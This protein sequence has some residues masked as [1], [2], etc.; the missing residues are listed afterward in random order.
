L[1]KCKSFGLLTP[2]LM[3]ALILT[4]CGGSDSAQ[5]GESE[6]DGDTQGMDHGETSGM[7]HDS[8]DQGVGETTTANEEVVNAEA[9]GAS[10]ELASEPAASQPGQPVTLS[11]RITD[12]S[13]QTLTNLPLDHERPMHLI[14][15]SSDLTQFQHI[16]PEIGTGDAYSVTTEFP[17]AGTYTL[18]DEFVY[19]GHKVLDRREL[20]VGE[21]ADTAPS[22]TRDLAP[23]TE[24]TITVAISGPE[25]IRA[26]EESSFTFTLT[27]GERSVT[28]LEPYLGA[29]AHVAVVSEDGEDFAHA[30]GEVGADEGHEDMG[31][32]DDMESMDSPP[33]AFGPEV[34]LHHTF[35]RPGLYKMWA[36]FSQ[37]GRVI[38]V[39]FVVE[40]H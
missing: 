26:G 6:S 39:P 31:S 14:A 16:H 10:V 1:K 8:M 11:Y 35:P 40:V 12:K 34:S 25:M 22:L 15:V 7:D 4:S 20:R 27:H 30:H 24:G 3:A 29:A 33:A 21:G 17:E 38:T 28:N 37:E 5:Q 18:Y 13:G 9:A 32:M 36:Q 2:L 19:E 23:K